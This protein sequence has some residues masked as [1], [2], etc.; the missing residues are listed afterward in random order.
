MLSKHGTYFG[1]RMY[2]RVAE[3]ELPEA[4][5]SQMSLLTYSLRS[6]LAG[7]AEAVTVATPLSHNTLAQ[8]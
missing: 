8:L 5:L 3:Q 7:G 1:H 6:Q 4:L 2:H